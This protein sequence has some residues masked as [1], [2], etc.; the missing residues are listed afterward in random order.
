MFDKDRW[1]EIFETIKKNKLRTFLAGFTVALGI[2]IFIMLFGLANG[3]ENT[4]E[5]YFKDDQL[6]TIWINGSR[7]SKP[8]AGY[9]SNRRIRFKNEDLEDIQ[10]KFN[11]FINGITPRITISSEVGYRLKSNNYTVRGVGP[12][13]QFNEMTVIMD[14]RYINEA[15]IFNKERNVVIGR[16][17]KQDLFGNEDPIGKFV[18]GGGRSWKV[19]G[20][21][22]DD[23]GDN[24][25]RMIYCSYTTLQSILKSSD[26]V[27]QIIV[28]YN[29]DIGYDGAIE[30][31]KNIKKYLKS[32]K[33]IDPNDPKGI[34]VRSASN[35]MQ[36]N[37]Q[38]SDAL[39]YMI[40]FIGIGT[41]FAGIIGISN[42]MV[43]VIKE[44]NK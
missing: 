7:T 36:Q 18:N 35:D 4:F 16:L 13:H 42:I 24:E 37:E 41:L 32:K 20:V 8:Y 12:H 9:E 17:V 3:L 31:E 25:E 19:V 14:G 44:R 28:S 5:K 22:Q 21:F 15:D 1:I 27:D 23:G 34:S 26:E 30:F 40:I 10:N 2:F 38:F 11:F 39:N 6:N 29:P 33:K 43:F